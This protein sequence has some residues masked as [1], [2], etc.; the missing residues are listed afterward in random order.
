MELAR[1]K[2]VFNSQGLF[3]PI[4]DTSNTVTFEMDMLVLVIYETIDTA[5]LSASQTIKRHSDG[6]V[7]VDPVSLET[8]HEG[9]FA[10]G[11]A[12]TGPKSA[13]DAIA[14]GKRAAESM[15][16]Y[17]EGR[18][19]LEGRLAED[20]KILDEV[21]FP[22]E[23]KVRVSIPRTAIADRKGFIETVGT[24]D[25]KSAVEE[26]KRCLGCRRCLGCG[27]CEEFCKPGAID[28]REGPAERVLDVGSIIIA[29]GF[30][31]FDSASM[32][33]FGYHAFDNVLEQ[34]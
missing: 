33:E 19:L 9:V 11:N 34:R 18:D 16:R 7:K 15:I 21:P 32:K 26:A 27:I 8:T 10:G 5:Y 30:D 14:H 13:I 6:R 3:D 31:E 2:Q 12:V 28:Y 22:V 23:R 24:L 29:C 17:L 25:E 4:Y 1:C 20:D